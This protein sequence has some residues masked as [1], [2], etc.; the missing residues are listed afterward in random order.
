MQFYKICGELMANEVSEGENRTRKEISHRI[1]AKTAEFNGANNS[2]Y[3]FLSDMGEEFVTIG[4][5]ATH[6][7]NLGDFAEE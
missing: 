5:I 2:E 6:S 3:C 1:A 4:I 7:M